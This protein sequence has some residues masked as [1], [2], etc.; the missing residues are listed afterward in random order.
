VGTVVGWVWGGAGRVWTQR[1]TREAETSATV[2]R[3][4]TTFW[5]DLNALGMRVRIALV[6]AGGLDL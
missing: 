3:M 6:G 2:G 4:A 5:D 1:R